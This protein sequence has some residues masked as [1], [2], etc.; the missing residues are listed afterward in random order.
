MT[1]R[2]TAGDVEIL[3]LFK[4]QSRNLFYRM[5]ALSNVNPIVSKV[6]SGS[7]QRL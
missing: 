2:Y 5:T 7:T 3:K 4:E 6:K 1:Q